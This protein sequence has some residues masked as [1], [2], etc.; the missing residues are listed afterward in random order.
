M[1]E[2]KT[3]LDGEYLN[4]YWADGLIISTPTGSPGYSLNLVGQL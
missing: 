4:T 1:I 3:N 2:G